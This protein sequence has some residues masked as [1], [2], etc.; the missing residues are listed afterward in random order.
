[1]LHSAFSEETSAPPLWHNFS[2]SDTKG[3][4]TDALYCHK[5]PRATLSSLSSVPFIHPG[6]L[7]L[8]AHHCEQHFS[9]HSLQRG[10]RARRTSSSVRKQAASW[11]SKCRS[12]CPRCVRPGAGRA[13]R[14]S[15]WFWEESAVAT[16]WTTKSATS[17][18]R[19][20]RWRQVRAEMATGQSPE[21]AQI[22]CNTRPTH[23]IINMQHKHTQCHFI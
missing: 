22:V 19:S 20:E 3:R 12:W 15:G 9:G 5:R 4:P 13:P 6:I 18:K 17:Q 21:R 11:R 2:P 8:S 16:R 7:S 23:A 1:M 14:C 10:V